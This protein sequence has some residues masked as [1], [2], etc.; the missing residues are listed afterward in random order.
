MNK[1]AI[2]GGPKVRTKLF[3]KQIVI[4]HE[5][6][7]A[8]NRVLKSGKLSGYRGSYIPEFMG[9]PEVQE[10]EQEFAEYH[11]VKYAIAVNSCTSALQICCG[12]IRLKQEDQVL[13]TPYSMSCSATAP[14]VYGATPIFVD[15]EY[16]HF[17]LDPDIIEN[18]ITDKTKAII[19]VDLFGQSYDADKINAIAK[20]H[21]LF[22]IE[23]AAQAIGS[24]YKGKLAGTLGDLGCFSF[25]AGKILSSGEGGIIVTNDYDL[26]MR[27]RLLR[28]HSEAVISS[29]DDETRN[30]NQILWRD[31]LP[32]FNMRMTEIQAAILRE[33]LK[34]LKSIVAKRTERTMM[35]DRALLGV[36]AISNSPTRIN[37]THSFYAQPFYWDSEEADGLHRD[38]FIDAVKA[39]LVPDEGREGEG[40]PIN[41]SYIRPL[42]M[43]P[44][45][46]SGYIYSCCPN[47]EKLWK[48]ALFLSLYHRSPLIE[49]DVSDISNAFYKCWTHR[50]E[51]L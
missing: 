26:A 2:N 45:F 23:D 1:L 19:V 43:M 37:C 20:K 22:V 17:C 4:E 8:V 46:K 5:E 40:V 24:T 31:H 34:K 49:E 32:G 51:L 41:S 42:Y 12:A 9:G 27:C 29:M 11:K 36:P 14:M 10:F 21:N 47:V 44:M 33:Q 48:D 35:L 15:I 39:E 30:S 18:A 28:N 16:D 25:T 50:K 3:P 13:V 38:K 6:I 7:E